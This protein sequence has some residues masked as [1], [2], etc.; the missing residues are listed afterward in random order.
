MMKVIGLLSWFDESPTWLAATVASFGRICD[1][2]VA[3]DGRYSMYEDD[4]TSST[5]E[6]HEAIVETCR[7][8][9]LGLTL[10]VAR[11]PYA[12]EMEKRTH[13]FQLASIHAE[14]FR[15]WFF[16]LDGDEVLIEAPGRKHVHSVLK[17]LTERKQS[18]ATAQLFEVVDPHAD[19][20]RDEISRKVE[21]DLH[22][23]TTTP[24]F[25]RALA[26]MRVTG[27]H[28][29]YSG[30]AEHGDREV[31]WGSASSEDL[32]PWHHFGEDV[33]IENR[34]LKRAI[35]R[36]KKRDEY[37]HLRDLSKIEVVHGA[38]K[39]ETPNPVGGRS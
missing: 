27:Y 34:C 9:G 4:R 18:V 22:Y 19:A 6:Q 29:H 37:Y 35:T 36:K 25:W 30:I 39:V 12:T 13:L 7:G 5:T 8:T 21:T 38:V 3:V 20:R 2:V 1:H 23:S 17:T 32:V 26:D 15:D 24:R 28:Y 14:T 11:R 16:I 31:L 33:L 10:D